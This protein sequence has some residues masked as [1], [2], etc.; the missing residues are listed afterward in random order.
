MSGQASR[1]TRLER[2]AWPFKSQAELERLSDAELSFHGAQLE[3]LGLFPFR[4]FAAW[5][6]AAT[7]G[8]LL[9]LHQMEDGERA[10]ALRELQAGWAAQG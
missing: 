7:D 6:A 9:A 5:G 4:R 10:A 8:E 3:R 2:Q 1:V